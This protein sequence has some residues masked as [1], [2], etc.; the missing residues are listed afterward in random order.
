MGDPLDAIDEEL[1]DVDVSERCAVCAL[2][3]TPCLGLCSLD[4]PDLQLAPTYLILAICTWALAL[5]IET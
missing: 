1:G 4:L 3:A 2:Q 5:D